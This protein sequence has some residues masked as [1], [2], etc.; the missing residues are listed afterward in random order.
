MCFIFEGLVGS[1]GEEVDVAAVAAGGGLRRKVRLRLGLWLQAEAA[2][3][4]VEC[5]PFK[6]IVHVIHPSTLRGVF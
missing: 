1:G 5:H 4:S 6:R 2:E 3:V